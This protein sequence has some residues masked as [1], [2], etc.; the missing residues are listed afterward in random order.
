MGLLHA[1]A[2]GP[3]KGH[4]SEGSD[5]DILLKKAI[6]LAPPQR[7]KLLETDESL[8]KAHH[9][10]ASQGDTTAPDAQDDVDL[11]YVC[12][13][14][15]RRLYSALS[16]TKGGRRRQNPKRQNCTLRLRHKR[17]NGRDT[18]PQEK[19]EDDKIVQGSSL[20]YRV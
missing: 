16:A 18:L 8:A 5:L 1:V 7:A 4:I 6:P 13:V 12:F 10:A 2:N 20:G 9:S 17:K 19:Q 14:K 3:A 15:G 11:H